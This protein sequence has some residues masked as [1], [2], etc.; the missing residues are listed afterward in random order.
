[1]EKPEDYQKIVD[2][3]WTIIYEKLQTIADSGAQIVLSKLPIGDLA[4]QF[5]A[6][7]DLFCA[8]RVP[9]EDLQRLAKATGGVI[10]T[11]VNGLTEENLGQCGEFEE[12]Q[13]GAERYNL[14]KDCAGTQSCTIVIRGGADQ[15]IEEAARSLNDAIEVVRRASK[16]T[17]VVAGG[18]AIEMEL[19]RCLRQY[20]KEVS[21]K[22]Q[23]V[24][25]AFAKALEVIPRTLSE[26]SGMDQT[27][28]LNKLRMLHAKGDAEGLWMGV[29][30]LN[31]RVADLLEA[32][33][34]EPALIR[35]GVLS[36]AAE[37]ACTIL[38][39]DQTVR[40]PKNEQDQSEAAKRMAAAQAGVGRG[41]GGGPGAG[42]GM[43]R[44]RGRR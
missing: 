40:N 8:G 16:A 29:D 38:S 27:D 6:D 23:L 35:I 4:T 34:W 30:V 43:G 21:G 1:M 36:S 24:I 26:N 20:V 13:L 14:F 11:T 32:H 17:A 25:N 3:E 37:A 41:R 12:I 33:V 5:F 28:V 9:I 39:I 15:Y 18:G 22:E 7:R 2:A 19:S 10:Q 44:G 42:R 31:G